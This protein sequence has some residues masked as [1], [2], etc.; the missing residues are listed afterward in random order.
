MRGVLSIV[1]GHIENTKNDF[2]AWLLLPPPPP[3]PPLLLLLLLLLPPP[4][5]LLLLL[6]PPPPL[7]CLPPPDARICFELSPLSNIASNFKLLNS[8]SKSNT[9]P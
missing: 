5:P 1:Y 2:V 3:P 9:A 6:L 7:C 4:P 8:A